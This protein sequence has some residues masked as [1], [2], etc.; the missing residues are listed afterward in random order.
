MANIEEVMVPDAPKRGLRLDWIFPMIFRPARQL[1]E[2]MRE[3]TSTWL[4]PLLLLSLLVVIAGLVAGPIRIQIAQ[5]TPPE[6]PQDFQ[7][8]SPDAQEQYM[9]ANQPNVSPLFMYGLPILGGLLGVWIG[10]FLLAAILHVMLTL[11][12]SRASRAADFSLAGWSMLPY[13]VRQLVQIGSML[14]TKSLITRPGLSGFVAADA[15]GV[16]AY[17]GALLSMVDIYL[18]WQIILLVIGASAGSGLKRG[19]AT[20]VVLVSVLIL[21]LLQAIPGFLG[22]QLGGLKVDRPFFFF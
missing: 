2:M 5:S 13:A 15:T 10:W 18:V 9:Q 4:T 20:G 8:W 6:I 14:V 17:V 11:N 3:E 7:Y 21:L 16:M 12:G 22:A 19:K 1:G